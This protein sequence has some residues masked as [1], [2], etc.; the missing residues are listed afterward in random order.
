MTE[1]QILDMNIDPKDITIE[2]I[3]RY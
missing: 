1:N 2:D 3:K